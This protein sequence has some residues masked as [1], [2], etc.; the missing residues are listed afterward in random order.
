MFKIDLTVFLIIT[1]IVFNIFNQNSCQADFH[2]FQQI[3]WKFMRIENI[4]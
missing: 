2:N 3:W 1:F 4:I